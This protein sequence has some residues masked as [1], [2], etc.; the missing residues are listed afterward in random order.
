MDPAL[1]CQSFVELTC[2]GGATDLHAD[3]SAKARAHR[4]SRVGREN[5]GRRAGIARLST[6]IRFISWPRKGDV[7]M[8][9]RKP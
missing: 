7:S 2:A 1:V 5:Q 8:V 6:A 4:D 9:S 3:T